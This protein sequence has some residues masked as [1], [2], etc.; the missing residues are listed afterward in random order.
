MGP[1]QLSAAAAPH[2]AELHD[3]ALSEQS[4]ASGEVVE[5]SFVAAASNTSE[6]GAT[7]EAARSQR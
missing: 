7:A 4:L 2:P 6:H 3:T 5:P 1:D